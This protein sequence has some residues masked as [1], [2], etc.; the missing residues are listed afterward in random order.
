MSFGALIN[1]TPFKIVLLAVNLLILPRGRS[2]ATGIR[3]E[4]YY[5]E[6]IQDTWIA[7]MD[8]VSTS[9]SRYAISL[10][11]KQSDLSV[12]WGPRN[13]APYGSQSPRAF[14]S[15]HRDA[16][17]FLYVMRDPSGEAPGRPEVSIPIL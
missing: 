6:T 11:V 13:Q 1:R 3:V 9:P 15:T 5:R 7:V 2:D 4:P 16:Q 10:T 14:F 8:T 17:R 12:V